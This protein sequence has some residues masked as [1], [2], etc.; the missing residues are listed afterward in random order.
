MK[1][2]IYKYLI[3]GVTTEKLAALRKAIAQV[4]QI[5]GLDFS[6]PASTLAVEASAN[7]RDSVELAC[8]VVGVQLR[9][10]IKR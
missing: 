9:A 1:R 8:R 3:D 5:T 10:E 2:R 4:P 6:I 7:P